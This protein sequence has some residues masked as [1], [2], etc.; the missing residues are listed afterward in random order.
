MR[1]EYTLKVEAEYHIGSG[2]T[3]PGLADE[4]IVRRHD[5]QLFIPAEY[6]RGLLRDCCTQIL[7]WTGNYKFCCDA[8]LYK[9]P[10]EGEMVQSSVTKTCGLNYRVN[11]APCVLCRIFVT[12]FAKKSYRFSDAEFEKFDCGDEEFEPVP[13][14]TH[15]RIDPATG[16]VPQDLLFTFELGKPAIFKGY[17]ERVEP[18]PKTELLLE[19]FGLI[20]AGLRLI[21]RIGKRS[22][23]GW[24][25]A[26]VDQISLA[27]RGGLK[28]E[29]PVQVKDSPEDWRVWLKAFL[30]GGDESEMV[31]SEG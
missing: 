28:D 1:I 26:Y 14:S 30:L 22:A 15:N 18:F 5:G 25:W 6:F 4:T 12:T 16:R 11:E 7:Y 17:I 23:R 8:A 13:I 21:E 20:I 31:A 27:L 19:E 3:Q 29:L 2:L 24:G 10:V 9:A